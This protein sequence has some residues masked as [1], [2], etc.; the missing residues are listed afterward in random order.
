MFGFNRSR[1]R[2]NHRGLDA[3]TILLLFNLGQRIWELERKPP[4]TLLLVA[5]ATLSW[6]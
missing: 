6:L 4:V 3:Y 1:G 5:G 2:Q